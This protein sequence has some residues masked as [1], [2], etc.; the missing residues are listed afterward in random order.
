MASIYQ[1]HIERR[2][3]SSFADRLQA[4]SI[5]R[6]LALGTVL[7]AGLVAWALT[8][9]DGNVA[10]LASLS[11]PFGICAV[12]LTMSLRGIFELSDDQLD[13]Y[14]IAERNRAYKLAYGVTVIFIVVLATT[15]TGLDLPRE[16]N[17][18]IAAF[19][20]LISVFEPRLIMAWYLEDPDGNE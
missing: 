7:S 17:F 11:V 15:A 20:F 3:N 5:R 19:A 12:L 8:A 1:K 14:Q 10:L 2:V 4:Q 13:E 18:A 16:Q 9:F 6:V